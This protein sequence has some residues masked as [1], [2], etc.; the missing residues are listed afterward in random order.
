M[1]A[2]DY[3]REIVAVARRRG[4]RL[5]SAESLTGGLVADAV[6]SVPGASHI[7]SGGVV[8]YDTSLKL[9]LL[10]V[11]AEL[12]QRVGPVDR[13][14]ARQMAVG[15]RRLCATPR[16]PGGAPEW[17]E[18]A[19]ATTGVAGPDPDPQTGTAVGVTWICVSSAAGDVCEQYVFAGDRMGIRR[20]ARD[21]A[22]QLVAEYLS[23]VDSSSGKTQE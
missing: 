5:A 9:S 23:E 19:V 8:A 21:A 10:G 16:R 12:L 20:A 11:D 22:L 3:A 6:V 15:A 13:E 18:I 7:F 2:A 1:H 14:V 4:I 17:A